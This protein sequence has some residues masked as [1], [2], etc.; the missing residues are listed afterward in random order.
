MPKRI[1]ICCDGTW[2]SPDQKDRGQV[3]PSNVAKIALAALTHDKKGVEQKIFY[4]K[5]VGTGFGLDRLFGGAFGVG[6]SRNIGDAYKYLVANYDEG[7]ELFLFGFSRGAYTARS[8]AGLIRNCGLLRREY[9]DRY[10][11]AYK[12]Y[13]RRDS[14][15]RPGAVEA[16]LFRKSYAHEIRI[17]FI[18][19]WDT[20]GAL[21]IP[22]RGLR[23]VNRL[24][25]LEFHD[26]KLSTYVDNAYQAVA[27]DEKRK[28]FMP[29]LW[30]QQSQAVGQKMEQVWFAG[31]HSN[32]GGGYEDT[33]LSD[34]AFL[35]M[36]QKA[37]DVGLVFDENWIAQNVHPNALGELRNSRTG[38]YKLSVDYHR[39][40]GVKLGGNESV[41]AEVMVRY[42]KDSGYQPENLM[43]YLKKST[44]LRR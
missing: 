34:I 14:H 15:S 29:T 2:N 37:G 31:V 42:E 20:V 17:K 30:E 5:G 28:P 6:I 1:V 23:F 38:L 41:H 33:G 8:L 40:I 36:K 22:V 35:W 18:G 12:L 3:C 27:I 13:R 9:A 39:P 32:I 21:G 19:V 4:D 16:Q 11:D 43:E 10:D 26:V 7:D 25:G 24:L 44:R